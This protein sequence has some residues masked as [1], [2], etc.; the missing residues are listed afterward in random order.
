MII[1]D[2]ALDESG[3]VRSC[4]I[5]GHA[6]SGPYGG[7]IVCAAVSVLARTALS[8]LSAIDGI[9]VVVEPPERGSLGFVVLEV[10]REGA[11]PAGASAFLV[12]GLSS[13]ARDYPDFCSV[14]V[15]TE[16]RKGN[17]Y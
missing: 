1:A 12:E 11:Y 16:R 15:R 17:G 4:S 3:I 8:T 10:P 7:D 5:E 9:A 13:I 2:V 14:R 6:G